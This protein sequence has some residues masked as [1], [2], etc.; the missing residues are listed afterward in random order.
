M[1]EMNYQKK[2]KVRSLRNVKKKECKFHGAK[3]H[4]L[5]IFTA[6]DISQI[7]FIYT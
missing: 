7:V 2:I 6:F 5:R 3:A 4:H 1:I